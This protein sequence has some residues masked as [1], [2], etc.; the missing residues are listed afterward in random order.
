M[1]T[2]CICVFWA[3]LTINQ[4]YFVALIQSCGPCI[5]DG[6]SFT[7]GCEVDIEIMFGLISCGAMFLLTLLKISRPF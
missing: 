5:G 6:I 4:Y 1:P 7:L 2:E 3:I